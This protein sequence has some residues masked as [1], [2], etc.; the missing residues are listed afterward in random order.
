[1][2]N[3]TIQIKTRYS[4][5]KGPGISFTKDNPKAV[6]KTQQ[7]FK[8]EANINCIMRKYSKSGLL[9]DPTV[10]PTRT[11]KF[12]DYSNVKDFHA[13]QNM[14][15]EI[16]SYFDSLPA[17]IRRKFDNDPHIMQEWIINPDNKDEAIKLGLL[18]TITEEPE[19]KKQM[20]S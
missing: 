9:T 7:H 8:K 2:E 12:D 14:I 6:S 10:I 11:P 16:Q 4:Y 13:M 5:A 17:D 19:K 15:L 18:E 1:M 3:Q 20:R